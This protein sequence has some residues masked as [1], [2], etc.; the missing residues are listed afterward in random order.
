MLNSRLNCAAPMSISRLDRIKLLLK[1][2]PALPILPLQR[3]L[4]SSDGHGR[5]SHGRE[6][7]DQLWPRLGPHAKQDDERDET[8]VE[9]FEGDW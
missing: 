2:L 8:P 3:R 9:N 5:A 7:V 4:P 1:R 6:Q